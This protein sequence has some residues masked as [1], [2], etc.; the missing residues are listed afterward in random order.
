MG[1]SRSRYSMMAEDRQSKVSKMLFLTLRSGTTPVLIRSTNRNRVG[2]TDS[3]QDLHFTF[4]GKTETIFKA[5]ATS[6][7]CLNKQNPDFQTLPSKY[8]DNDTLPLI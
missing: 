2:Y 3:I 7:R 8:D 1:R 5:A 4:L 6:G